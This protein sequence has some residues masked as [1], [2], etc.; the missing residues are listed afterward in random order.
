[1]RQPAWLKPNDV[2]L[3]EMIDF[4]NINDI[5]KEEYCVVMLEDVDEVLETMRNE[6]EPTI[7]GEVQPIET[8]VEFESA[9]GLKGFE[10]LHNIVLDVGDQFLCSDV[11]TGAR[12]MYDELQR[13]FETFQRNVNNLKLNV[14]CKNSCIHGKWLYMTCSNNKVW[15]LIFVKKIAHLTGMCI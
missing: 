3:E 1:M 7:D 10:A 11:Q 15:T 12:Q 9:T 6:E 2:K 13:T 8:F 4:L 5:N 14:K